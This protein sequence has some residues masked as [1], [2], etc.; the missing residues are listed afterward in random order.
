[1][2]V[3]SLALVSHEVVD[4]VVSTC[5]FNDLSASRSL[6]VCIQIKKC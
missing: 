3:R 4:M 5:R 1:M 6:D 2:R